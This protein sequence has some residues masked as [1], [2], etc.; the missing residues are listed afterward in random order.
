MDIQNADVVIVDVTQ[1]T[2]VVE[3]S[4]AVGDDGG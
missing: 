1:R 2:G 4:G 3:E